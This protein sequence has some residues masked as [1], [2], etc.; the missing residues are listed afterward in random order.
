MPVSR[1]AAIVLLPASLLM[2]AAAPAQPLQVPGLLQ[3]QQGNGS[4][5]TEVLGSEQAF[6]LTPPAPS[7]IKT[8]GTRQ[9]LQ[10]H[11][12][13]E[14][15]YY[16]YRD[17]LKLS[18]AQGQSL[19]LNI[20]QGQTLTDAF[21]GTVQVF[22]DELRIEAAL[23]QRSE[24]WPLQLQWQGCA[25]AGVCYPPQQQSISAQQ[26]GQLASAEAP[27]IGS[28]VE[29]IPTSTSSPSWLQSLALPAS[30][31]IGPMA[32]PTMALASFLAM[33]LS[34]WW[35]R[36]QQLRLEQAVD[37]LLMRSIL[38]GLLAARLAYVGQWWREYLQPVTHSAASV[39]Q[40]VDIRD[41]GWNLWAG[42]A[43]AAAWTLW[44]ARRNIALRHATLQALAAG[45][46]ILIAAHALRN[47]V[48]PEKPA[49]P[50][51]TLVTASTQT[52]D[53]RSYQGQP[54]VINLWATW[55]PPCRREMPVLAQAQKEHPDIRFLWINQGEDATAVM[56]YLQAMAL[57]L[58]QVLLDPEQRASAHWQQRGLPSTYF[59][60]AQG[61]LRGMR[62][63][64]LSRASL[65]E[66]LTRIA[67]ARP[68]A[69]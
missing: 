50:A 59:Y 29:A 19:T 16:L 23:P 32:L 2:G 11:W 20:P 13:I 8:E 47:W 62:M 43:A 45:A 54:L 17:Q 42:L 34:Q 40:I 12:R 37:A 35:A 65:A 39:L 31:L 66:Q 67:P 46:F 64:E 10:L 15:G 57:P 53:L 3:Q 49:I 55:C 5:S 36:R 27:S 9:L 56:R 52:V 14:P 30:V 69:R 18:D 22:H 33:L 38:V 41:G 1:L 51:I 68:A 7:A 61:Q 48:E 44:R 63:G 21:F 60:D 25:H 6:V 26:L 4:S 28:A 24:Q 58:P